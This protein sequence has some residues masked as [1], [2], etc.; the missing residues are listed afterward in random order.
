MPDAIGLLADA[1]NGGAKVVREGER[2]GIV[3]VGAE[4]GVAEVEASANVGVVVIQDY[5]FAL[6]TARELGAGN[7]DLRLLVSGDASVSDGNSPE[8]RGG[9]IRW[10]R[11]WIDVSRPIADFGGDARVGLGEE[12]NS[13][14]WPNC[15]VTA[16]KLPTVS[17]KFI[18]NRPK[19]SADPDRNIP[20]QAVPACYA[21]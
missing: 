13:Q 17:P 7:F 21:V 10:F 1:Q 9:E 3:G 6:S 2:E 14:F 15:T 11:Y 16:A 12:S 5:F 8:H 19:R 18:M 4:P 20:R